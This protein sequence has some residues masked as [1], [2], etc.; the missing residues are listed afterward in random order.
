MN[1]TNKNITPFINNAFTTDNIARAFRDQYFPYKSNKIL[2]LTT[3]T[4]FPRIVA[5]AIIYFE[6]KFARKYLSIFENINIL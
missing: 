5:G 4:V 1:E 2:Y 6:A 3:H